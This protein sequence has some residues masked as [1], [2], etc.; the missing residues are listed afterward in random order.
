MD[1]R[2]LRYFVEVAHAGTIAAASQ[3]LSVSASP[4]SRRIT[5]LE[6]HM[7]QQLFVRG[8]RRLELTPTGRELLPLAEQVLADFGRVDALRARSRRTIRVGL[9]PG[10]TAEV[11]AMIEQALAD[12]HPA[13]DVEFLPASSREQ[14]ARVLAGKLDFATVRKV[15]RD[16]RLCCVALAVESI[17]VVLSPTSLELVDSPL[18]PHDL[19]GWTLV[20]SHTVRFSDDLDRFLEEQGVT[21]IRVIPRADTSA[22]SVLLQHGRRFSLGIEGAPFAASAPVVR[23]VLPRRLTSRTWLVWRRDRQDLQPTIDAVRGAVLGDAGP[24]PD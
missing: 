24:G 6:R 1:V 11:T 22:L 12:V 20:S 4:L 16:E 2:H 23:A 17:E 15:D 3:T 14:N 19:A 21:D 5:E 9:V 13:D 18:G 10:I 7:G 8:G